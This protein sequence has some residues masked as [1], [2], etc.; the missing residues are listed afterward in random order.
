MRESCQQGAYYVTGEECAIPENEEA[1][2]VETRP[3]VDVT[4]EK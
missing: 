3:V 1:E 2:P 4:G